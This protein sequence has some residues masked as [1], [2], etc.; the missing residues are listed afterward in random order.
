[1]APSS[2]FSYLRRD[3][4]ADS[5]SS[6]TSPLFI[7]RQSHGSAPHLPGIPHSPKLV[8]SIAESPEVP[9]SE[10]E[11][12][13]YPRYLSVPSEQQSP[14]ET[15]G[16]DYHH[17]GDFN[18]NNSAK[19]LHVPSSATHDRPRPHSSSE[20]SSHLS[21]FPSH[22]SMYSTKTTTIVRPEQPD[23]GSSSSKPT[24]PWRLAF[25]KGLLNPQNIPPESQK[26]TPAAYTGTFGWRMDS[27]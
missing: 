13:S 5:S 3:R 22:E 15:G 8:D 14:R 21:T 4:R 27:S 19:T 2:V 12:P 23:T 16:L 18:S 1:M 10:S 9:S 7:S 24:S 6:P 25:G 17:L 26:V 11:S 20:Q